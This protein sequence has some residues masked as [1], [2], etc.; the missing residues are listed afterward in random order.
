MDD[1]QVLDSGVLR[2]RSFW[3]KEMSLLNYLEAFHL[4][5]DLGSLIRSLRN[6]LE[7]EFRPVAI[8]FSLVDVRKKHLVYYYPEVLRG[9]PVVIGEGF[10]GL[11]IAAGRYL[12][13]TISEGPL[14]YH[15]LPETLDFVRPQSSVLV[16]PLTRDSRVIGT[17]EII[18]RADGSEFTLDDLNYLEALAPHMTIALN[19]FILSMEAR[20]HEEEEARLR[21]ISRSISSTLNLDEILEDILQHLR[22]L[23][24]YDAA[25]ILLFASQNQKRDMASFGM[26]EDEQ[27]HLLEQATRIESEW[28]ELGA[29]PRLLSQEDCEDLRYCLRTGES[30]ILM[31][32]RN[33]D[34][35]LGMF[36]L[37]SD[38][39]DAFAQ[40]D[41]ELLE[42]FASQ[43]TF[44]IERA[45]LHRSLIEKT[46]LE[47]ELRI[48]R[49]IQLRFLPREMPQI[50]GLEIAAKNV[51]SRHV[52]GDYYDFIP[53][54]KGQ[55]GIVIG[56]VSS[57]GI[58]AGLIMS[59]FRA[60]LLAEIRNNFAITTILQKV[61]RLLWETTDSN[62]FVTAFYGV[63][64]EEERVLTY[65]NAG[66][67]FPILR[68]ADGSFHDLQTGGLLLGAFEHVQYVEERVHLHPGDLLV[69]YTDGVTEAPGP[70]GQEFGVNGLKTI[71]E[72]CWRSSASEI[73]DLLV[74]QATAY[75]ES[76][77]PEDDATLMVIKV[78]D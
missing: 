12:R 20:R 56:D 10:S 13:F 58:S 68:R 35:I 9:V 28:L 21:E 78:V 44:A 19:H 74:Q 70:E 11:A 15:A 37:I 50:S 53:I 59:A 46:Q 72:R 42:A 61:N 31:P 40:A 34:R 14:P 49:E 29:V 52:S 51:A 23:M 16:A 75:S 43:A 54:V 8:H 48:A 6:L 57:K 55:W 71:M 24:P 36:I 4:A 7:D 17:V 41:L 5:P 2:A 62:R 66:H 33:A 76:G 25:A 64:D 22:G 69:L 39:R 27:E 30:Q 1:E 63:F 65:S 38:Q 67:N 60:S 3:R 73:A 18:D 47:Q 26:T 77:V 45:Q 32:L